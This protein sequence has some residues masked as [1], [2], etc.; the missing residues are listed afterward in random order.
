MQLTHYYIS[1]LIQI[2][3]NSTTLELLTQTHIGLHVKW[4]IKCQT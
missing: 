3:E 1:I 2:G 4:S